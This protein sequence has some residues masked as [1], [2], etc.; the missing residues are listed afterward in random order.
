M[1]SDRLWMDYRL[2]KL[3][4]YLNEIT[5]KLLHPD[6]SLLASQV[7]KVADNGETGY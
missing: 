2:L 7:I 1:S 5:M 6:S 3:I 4:L